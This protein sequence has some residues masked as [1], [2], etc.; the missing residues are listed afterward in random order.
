MKKIKIGGKWIGKGK[1]C[2]IIAEAGVNHNGDIDLAKKLIDI[3]KDAGVDAVKFQTFKTSHLVT[4]QTQM[5]EYQKKNI[6]RKGG[7]FEMM[8][9]VE[10]RYEDFN[11][12]KKYCD[13][14]RIM[15]LS[16]PHETDAVEWLEPLVPVFKIGSGD[17]TNLPFLEILAKKKKP[18]ILS[19]GMANLGE[20]E[21]AI[22]T[23]RKNG[24]EN[25]I[26][27]H[28]TTSYPAHINDINLRAMQT[29]E[30]AFKLLA[31][32]SDHTLGITIP[33]VA[34]AMGAV[35]IEKHFT[36]DR[37]FCGPDHKASLE[38]NELKKMVKGIRE[39]EK[40]L[41]NGIKKPT[42]EE[43]NIKKIVRKSI[44]ARIDIL[45]GS[46]ITK[47]MLGIKRPG[48]GL[49]PK[50]INEILGATAKINI[51]RDDMISW[52]NIEMIG[53]RS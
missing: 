42:N 31:G 8:K 11:E 41:G 38:P 23:L 49:E 43:E 21:E 5:A 26:V 20:V 22:E 53:D 46:T 10:L 28:C 37:T 35:M 3:A 17:L 27:L 9:K 13:K 24:C 50:Y 12:L 25:I 15:F 36:I 52:D 40:A 48:T 18:I 44:V 16:T 39:I 30:H 45:K 29:L 19:T 4:K 51:N 2:F 6:G 47:D 1:P 14:K 34:V 33:M 32:Y 7:Q